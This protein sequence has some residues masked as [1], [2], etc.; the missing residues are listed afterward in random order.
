MQKFVGLSVKKKKK[1]R[2][3]EKR[4]RVKHRKRGKEKRWVEHGDKSGSNPFA[5]VC[6]SRAEGQ[7]AL[8]PLPV[9]AIVARN[10]ITGGRNRSLGYRVRGFVDMHT[11]LD[12]FRIADRPLVRGGVENFQTECSSIGPAQRAGLSTFFEAKSGCFLVSKD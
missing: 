10:A 6:G 3:K 9:C 4:K 11:N 7:R 5:A 8:P 2:K 12:N 1:E